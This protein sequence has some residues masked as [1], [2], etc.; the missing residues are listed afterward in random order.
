MAGRQYK[1]MRV[2]IPLQPTIRFNIESRYQRGS[3]GSM[4]VSAV[5]AE[6]CFLRLHTDQKKSKRAYS[7]Y[8]AKPGG[9][10]ITYG[11]PRTLESAERQTEKKRNLLRS[12]NQPNDQ[13]P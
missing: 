9:M 3:D 5:V 2:N 4:N 12:S 7:G 8:M 11:M 13:R 1:S 10:R 6:T